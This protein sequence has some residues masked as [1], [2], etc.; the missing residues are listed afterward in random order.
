[1]RLKEKKN[2]KRKLQIIK[3]CYFYEY[4]RFVINYILIEIFPLYNLKQKKSKQNY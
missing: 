2:W 3:E 1:M 4:S